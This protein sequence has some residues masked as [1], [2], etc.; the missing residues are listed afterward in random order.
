M[1][2]RSAVNR[3]VVGSNPTWGV[4]VHNC[5]VIK[6]KEQKKISPKFSKHVRLENFRTNFLVLQL[7]YAGTTLKIPVRI[8]SADHRPAPLQTIL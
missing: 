3:F 7:N 4:S 1:V 5:K 8:T 2:E 6:K